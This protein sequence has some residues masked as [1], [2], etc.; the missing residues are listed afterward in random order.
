LRSQHL[1]TSARLQVLEAELAKTRAEA[2]AA[3]QIEAALKEARAEIT[4]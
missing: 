2:A 3:Q 1:D 4:L